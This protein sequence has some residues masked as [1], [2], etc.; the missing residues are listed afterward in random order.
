M[1]KVLWGKDVI[2]N[3][4]KFFVFFFSMFQLNPDDTE[5][6]LKLYLKPWLFL[7]LQDVSELQFIILGITAQLPLKA[8]AFL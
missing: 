8:L 6:L 7:S 1:I 4:K 5:L 3:Q 2:G